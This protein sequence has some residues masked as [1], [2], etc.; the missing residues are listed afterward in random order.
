MLTPRVPLSAELAVFLLQALAELEYPEKLQKMLLTA[1]REMSVE[2][3]M[4]VKASQPAAD[5]R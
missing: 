4:Q 3:V 1:Q 5:L 2:L